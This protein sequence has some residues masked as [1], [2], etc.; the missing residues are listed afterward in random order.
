MEGSQR[1]TSKNKPVAKLIRR[2][3]ES[4]P[5]T[6]RSQSLGKRSTQIKPP[7]PKRSR[8]S[9]GEMETSGASGGTGEES[10]WADALDA[11]D[12]EQAKTQDPFPPYVPSDQ[13]QNGQP[14][15]STLTT[16]KE[17][18]HISSITKQIG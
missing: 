12:A 8:M 1:K 16:C 3:I 11:L 7:S 5:A 4:S 2:D 10:S 13:G 15:P 6:T 18:F 17:C 9:E 14:P